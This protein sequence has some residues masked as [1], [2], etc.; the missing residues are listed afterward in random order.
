MPF[1]CVGLCVAERERER[2][3]HFAIAKPQK[4]CRRT[5]TDCEF[6]LMLAKAG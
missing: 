1:M 5:E 4:H 2:G 6:I 3:M